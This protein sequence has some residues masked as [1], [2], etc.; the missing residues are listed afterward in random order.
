MLAGPACGFTASTTVSARATA[1]APAAMARVID[2]VVFGLAS[3][4]RTPPG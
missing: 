2:A 3:S 4:R 1:A